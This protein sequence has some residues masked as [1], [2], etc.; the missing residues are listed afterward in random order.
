VL[1]TNASAAAAAIP[2][3]SFFMDFLSENGPVPL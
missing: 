3:V 1:T 2:L